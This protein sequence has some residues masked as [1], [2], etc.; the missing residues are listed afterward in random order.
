MECFVVG[1]IW[2]K[3]SALV[4]SVRRLDLV[5]YA[6]PKERNIKYGTIKLTE[7]YNKKPIRI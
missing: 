6:E 5:N 4:A 3:F 1:G 7:F 2:G